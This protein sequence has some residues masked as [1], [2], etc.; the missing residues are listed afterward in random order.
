MI[1]I[2][3]HPSRYPEPTERRLAGALQARVLPGR[4]LY[5]SPAQA[6]RWLAYHHAF[7]PSRTDTDV[8]AIYDAAFAATASRLPEAP[9]RHVSLGSGGGRK[10]RRM[11][12]AVGGRATYVAIDTSP[13]LVAQSVLVAGDRARELDPRV[14]DL[15]ADL[16]PD[17]FG[18]S[19]LPRLFTAFGMVPN[20]ELDAFGPRL[21]RWLR[22]D[23]WLLISF[24]LSPGPFEEARGRILPQYDNPPGRAWMRGALLE[25]GI[26]ESDASLEISARGLE[27]D[28]ETWRIEAWA[29]LSRDLALP[30][31][32]GTVAL[33]AEE[34]IRVL[35]SNRLTAAAATR[36]LEGWGLE[37]VASWIA[38][39][40]EE[41]V[42][43]TRKG[44]ASPDSGNP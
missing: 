3:L 35:I 22:P 8:E 26:T 42:W 28:G 20:F 9:I 36:L 37:V 13:S 31:P 38:P 12:A 39:S 15:D 2:G 30:M 16:G 1:R 34:R 11:L 33:T 29:S 4:F 44:S 23:D 19:D 5:D 6:G 41:G 40:N 24:N 21:S 14:M 27:E 7:S 32:W 10:D 18:P 17:D 25:L 43:L